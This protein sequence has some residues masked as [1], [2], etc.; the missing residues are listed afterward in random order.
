VFR[1]KFFAVVL[2]GLILL[3]MLGAC[4]CVPFAML[5]THSSVSMHRTE[6]EREQVERMVP[7]MPS[8]R[9]MGWA[10]FRCLLFL[11]PLG[12]LGMLSL[13]VL[14]S[15]RPRA[16]RAAHGEKFER[17]A[18]RWRRHGPVPPCCWHWERRRKEEPS[19]SDQSSDDEEP[20]MYAKADLEDFD[21]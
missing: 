7:T 14:R 18:E 13:L 17:W 1:G 2:I 6:M 5:F 21:E 12:L 20:T 15:L 11:L 10:P 16:W 8:M 3:G 9:Y 19:D 4:A